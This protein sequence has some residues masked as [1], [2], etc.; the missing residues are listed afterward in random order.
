VTGTGRGEVS[1]KPAAA[2]VQ[3]AL[4]AHGLDR[5]VIELP[6]EARTAQQAADAVGVSVAQIAKSLVWSVE[7]EPVMVI[8]SGANRVDESRLAALAGGRVRRASPEL[9]REATGYVIGG[10]APVGYP[11]PLRTW[12]DRDLL[13]HELIYAAAGLPECVFPLSPAEL[14]RITGG[15]VVDVVA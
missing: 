9:V 3:A 7:G 2:R 1:L 4:A 6:V 10:V 13:G 5:E 11:R 15:Q 12:I 8:A 14:V